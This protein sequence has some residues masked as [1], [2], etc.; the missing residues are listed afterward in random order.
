MDGGGQKLFFCSVSVDILDGVVAVDT[1]EDT[2]I[3]V[4]VTVTRR[5]GVVAR[6]LLERSVQDLQSESWMPTVHAGN[7]SMR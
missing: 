5:N 7:W 4:F 6:T 3:L 1:P 2:P